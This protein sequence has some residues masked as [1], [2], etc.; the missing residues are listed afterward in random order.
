MEPTRQD[1]AGEDS[2]TTGAMPR[3]GWTRVAMAIRPMADSADD[4]LLRIEVA[5]HEPL[6]IDVAAGAFWWDT[7]LADMPLDPMDVRIARETRS[8]DS[9]V[10][11]TPGNDLDV[12]LWHIGLNSFPG[13]LAW[14]MQRDDRYRLVRWP[15]L[16]TLG[17]TPDQVRMTSLLGYAFLTVD[18][19][20]EQANVPPVEA[21]RLVNAFSLMRILRS[22][23]PEV[24]MARPV[25]QRVD[26]AAT[27]AQAAA[28]APAPR[29]SLFRRL[30]ERLGRL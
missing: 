2:V 29:P 12:L 28:A 26:T 27:A 15:N 11:T 30:R 6:L 5:G 25:L 1:V 22:E 18:E 16:T 4:E 21:R 7:D 14:W 10:S 20:A 17:H 24:A 9:V 19:L 8:E 13:E 3:F 23:S